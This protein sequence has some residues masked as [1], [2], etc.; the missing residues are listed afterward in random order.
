KLFPPVL[1][2]PSR[3]RPLPS[4]SRESRSRGRAIDSIRLD[5]LRKVLFFLLLASERA[6]LLQ[7]DGRRFQF[8]PAEWA[9]PGSEFPPSRTVSP[10]SRLR[11]E[12]TAGQERKLRASRDPWPQFVDRRERLAGRDPCR[13]DSA[14]R[15]SILRAKN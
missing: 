2:L 6:S 11:V 13:K 12:P 9:T 8:Q 15:A 3:Y 10:Q 4:N 7:R 14:P 5:K 1:P